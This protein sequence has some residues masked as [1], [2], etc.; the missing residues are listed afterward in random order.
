MGGEEFDLTATVPNLAPARTAPVDLTSV[1]LV[2]LVI[3]ALLIT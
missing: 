2:L 1:V 3:G